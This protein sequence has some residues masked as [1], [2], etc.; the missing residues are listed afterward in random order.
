MADT[1]YVSDIPVGI[2]RQSCLTRRG[3]FSAIKAEMAIHVALR[4]QTRYATTGRC[5]CRRTSSACGRRRIAGR[6]SELLAQARSKEAFHQ[7]AAGPARQLPRA[8]RLP[9]QDA[10]A[11]RRRR[12][13]RRDVGTSTRSTSFSSR[14][15][16]QFPFSY[17]PS[18][19]REL[20]PFLERLPRRRQ[21]CRPRRRR[22]HS[23]A[24]DDRFSRRAQSVVL[25]RQCSYIIRLEP[26]V[27]T[28]EDT[29][30]LCS[31]SC[32]D[33]AWLLVQVL[34]HLGLAARFVSGY[35]IQLKPDVK[36]LDGPSGTD[37]GLHRP[38][39]VDRSLPAWCGL[40]RARPHI[41]ALAGEGHIPLAATPDPQ[42]AAPVTGA[43]DEC[44][45]DLR[46]RDERAADLR[47]AARHQAVHRRPVA[48]DRRPRPLHRHGALG[49]RRAP[50]DGRR[51][52]VR[53]DRR[54]G[55]RRVELH[56][57]R[58]RQAPSG[59]HARP[60]PEATIRPGRAAALRP[61]QVVS[62]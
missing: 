48:T 58:S 47:V 26:G 46:S 59:R 38:A 12:A 56:G 30:T 17:E 25:L 14:R 10:G 43:V 61:G 22:R 44:E 28:P 1:S 16:R 40:D 20:A 37:V 2:W 15:P 53:V 36:A 35:L 57:A 55:R 39:R 13:R 62:G 21:A 3:R 45:V 29:L 31:G 50:D 41:G 33:S 7:L 32:R 27:Q 60:A 49:A 23:F 5:R 34:R 42:G 51:A 8:R 6:R 24:A 11:R 52:D 54:H 19:A 9:G 4:H 18:L